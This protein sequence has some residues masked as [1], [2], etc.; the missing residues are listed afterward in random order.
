MTFESTN[1]WPD[2]VQVIRE[3]DNKVLG[4]SSGGKI[5]FKDVWA[6]DK[7]KVVLSP[8]T[9]LNGK[10][11]KYKIY[12]APFVPVGFEFSV[13]AGKQRISAMV[14]MK[15]NVSCT[16]KITDNPNP[17]GPPTKDEDRI[18]IKRSM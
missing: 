12:G 2:G 4:T 8:G 7:F 17:S 16:G 1:T 13:Q 5:K 18:R 11:L 6:N 15:F 9:T 14:R 3:R 10:E